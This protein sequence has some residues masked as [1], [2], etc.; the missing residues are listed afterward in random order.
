MFFRVP[1]KKLLVAS[2]FLVPSL[3]IAYPNVY[4]RTNELVFSFKI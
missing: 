4:Y 3:L 1:F 2:K